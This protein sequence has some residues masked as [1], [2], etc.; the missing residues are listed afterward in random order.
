[1]TGT[2]SKRLDALEAQV[3]ADKERRWSE[4]WQQFTIDELVIIAKGQA[5]AELLARWVPVFDLSLPASVIAQAEEYG[6]RLDAGMLDIDA[7]IE[8]LLA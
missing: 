5:P 1:M 3:E 6:R 7:E 2:I 8:R 4:F